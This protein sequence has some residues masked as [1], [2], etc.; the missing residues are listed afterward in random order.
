[1]STDTKPEPPD[2]A[3]PFLMTPEHLERAEDML[4]LGRPDPAQHHENLARLIERRRRCAAG[5]AADQ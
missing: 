5:C 1:M 3:Y 2:D 4:Q